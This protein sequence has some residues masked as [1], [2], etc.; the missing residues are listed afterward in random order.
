V[1]ELLFNTLQAQGA[2]IAELQGQASERTRREAALLDGLAVAQEA[3]ARE[4]RDTGERLRKLELCLQG[5][6]NLAGR[7]AA[8]D[9][10][11][12]MLGVTVPDA[13][14]VR[15]RH[16]ACCYY[17]HCHP[18]AFAVVSEWTAAA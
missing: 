14:P 9:D 6:S 15:S 7:H 17:S 13:E 11:A 8:L 1:L 4:H 16:C 5:A 18:A 10:I 12:F 3:A 2:A